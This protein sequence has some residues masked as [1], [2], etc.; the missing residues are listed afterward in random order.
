MIS[1]HGPETAAVFC[2][3]NNMNFKLEHKDSGSL[4]RAGIVRTAHG[5]FTTPR[6]MP[7]GTR[8]CVKAMPHSELEALGADII[9][10]NTYHLMTR[11]GKELVAS[12]GGLH[13]FISWKRSILT[14]SGGFQVYSLAALRDI[15]DEGVTFKSH[16][17]G[18]KMFLGPR[19]SMAVQQAL[20][21][22]IAMAFDEC[23]PALSERKAIEKAV[24]RTLRWA[25]ICYE[26]NRAFN[27]LPHEEGLD[28]SVPRQQLFAIV[29]GGVLDDERIRCLEGLLPYDFPG[30]AIGGLAVGEPTEEMY[31]VCE[32]LC[33]SHMP[34]EKPRYLMGVGTPEDLVMCV[35]RG[36][37]MFDCVMPTRNARNGTA[38]TSRG[39]VPVK[40]GR[41]AKDERPL[42]EGCPCPVCQRFTRG[43]LRHLFNVGE[44]LAGHYLTVHNLYFYLDLMRKMREA[45]LEDRTT[46]FASAFLSLRRSGENE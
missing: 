22:D 15:T 27:A 18:Q 21:S 8:G 30:F 34:S 31:R 36:V 40:A 39:N 6:F 19:E 26:D 44:S 9:L 41:F 25:K 32:L 10:G 7:V 12:M 11:P 37:D 1:F 33:S 5:T 43:Y 2:I 16:V 3:I 42:E 35:M 38:F 29:Q 14:D 13:K 45:I 23:P 4:A 28:D 24:N 46:E 17:D 20:G